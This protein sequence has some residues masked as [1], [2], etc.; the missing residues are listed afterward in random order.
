MILNYEKF[1]GSA[2]RNRLRARRTLCARLDSSGISAAMNTGTCVTTSV[3][4]AGVKSRLTAARS[5]A[6]MLF[7]VLPRLLERMRD[8]VCVQHSDEQSADF[9]NSRFLI[10]FNFTFRSFSFATCSYDCVI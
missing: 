1:G 7:A 9:K 3:T 10:K 2:S 5:T 8:C 6:C 4:A